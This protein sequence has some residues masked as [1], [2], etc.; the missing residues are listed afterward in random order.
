MAD[1]ANAAVRTHLLRSFD[2]A[3][4]RGAPYRHW[5]L[6]DVLPVALCDAVRA[7][8]FAPP[9]LGEQEGRRDAYNSTRIFCGAENQERFSACAALADAFQHPATIARLNTLCGHCL[10]GSFLRIEYCLDTAGFW[11]APHTDIGAKRFTMLVYLSTGP[12]SEAWG[13][14]LL[15]ADGT[16]VDRP[17]AGENSGL[18]FIPAED[19][20]HGFA[21]RPIEGVRHSL[22]VNYVVPEWQSRHELAFPERP[23][24][25]GVA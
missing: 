23:V 21:P 7:L 18:I 16:L 4:G 2:T 17:V 8:P 24:T 1:A 11:L 9:A 3:D 13:T 20:W 25:A 6:R 10:D 19:T 12:G 15:A 5:R 22:I 14:D